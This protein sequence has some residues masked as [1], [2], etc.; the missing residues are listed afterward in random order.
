MW[1]VKSELSA[2]SDIPINDPW[3]GDIE[4]VPAANVNWESVSKLG[5][6]VLQAELDDYLKLR[7]DLYN[8]K[9]KVW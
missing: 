1:N 7:E 3:M 2:K 4:I 6:E 9:Q 5:K 8:G